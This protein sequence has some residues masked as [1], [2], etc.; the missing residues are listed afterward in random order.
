MTLP[1]PEDLSFLFHFLNEELFPFLSVFGGPRGDFYLRFWWDR[2][3]GLDQWL[4]VDSSEEIIHQLGRFE[5]GMQSAALAGKRAWLL[6]SPEEIYG[7]IAEDLSKCKTHTY[8]E[9]PSSWKDYLPEDRPL[10]EE[11]IEDYLGWLN[12]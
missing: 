11:D 10:H 12:K 8:T 1:L 2:E 5:I 3:D 9:N 7:E 6:S 4:L